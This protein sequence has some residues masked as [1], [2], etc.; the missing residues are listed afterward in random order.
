MNGNL[1]FF[2]LVLLCM[3]RTSAA[4]HTPPV[5]V[6]HPWHSPAAP[7]GHMAVCPAGQVICSTGAKTKHTF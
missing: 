4:K 5:L 3:T 2:I 6:R 1:E 7:L